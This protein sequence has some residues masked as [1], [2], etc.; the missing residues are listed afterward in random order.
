MSF[1]D[2]PNK[3]ETPEEKEARIKAYIEEVRERCSKSSN[4]LRR[5]MYE[6]VY[7]PEHEKFVKSGWKDHVPPRAPEIFEEEDKLADAGMIDSAD[8][9]DLHLS[10][11]KDFKESGQPGFYSHKTEELID[12]VLAGL[13]W[14]INKRVENSTWDFAVGMKQFIDGEFPKLK[15]YQDKM[16][17]IHEVLNTIHGTALPGERYTGAEMYVRDL[18]F[19]KWQTEVHKVMDFLRDDLK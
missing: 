12:R 6:G 16:K 18:K 8:L 13:V 9:L 5:E 14:A 4:K 10:E 7:L 15:N 1:E 3:Q 11:L 2:I 17:L 19:T